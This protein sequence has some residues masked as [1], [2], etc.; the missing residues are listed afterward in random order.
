MEGSR[1]SKTRLEMKPG[2]FSNLSLSDHQSC[3]CM[4]I[5]QRPSEELQVQGRM[6]VISIRRLKQEKVCRTSRRKN[7]IHKGTSCWGSD[8]IV[9]TFSISEKI[10]VLEYS[11]VGLCVPK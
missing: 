7:N 11:T 4:L 8:A 2:S 3:P 1:K 10:H 9:S 5:R 6:S